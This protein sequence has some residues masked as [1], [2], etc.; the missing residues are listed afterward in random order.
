MLK[1]PKNLG[2][3]CQKFTKFL[4]SPKADN[5]KANSE[6]LSIE[7]N[8][9]SVYSKIDLPKVFNFFDKNFENKISTKITGKLNKNILRPNILSKII[10]PPKANINSEII[11][12]TGISKFTDARLEEF[13]SFSLNK[14]KSLSSE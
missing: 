1:F 13:T 9:L 2:I 10:I 8:L 5:S 12:V 11:E 4:E 7:F 14:F 6:I 3:Y